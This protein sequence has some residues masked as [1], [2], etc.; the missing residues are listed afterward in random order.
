[1]EQ[2]HEGLRGMVGGVHREMKEALDAQRRD[3]ESVDAS[4]K[5][6]NSI[7]YVYSL[8]GN[9]RPSEARRPWHR[10]TSTAS[11]RTSCDRTRLR[12]KRHKGD[13]RR[14]G[15]VRDPKCSAYILKF[16]W[17]P[18]MMTRDLS[19]NSIHCP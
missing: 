13:A 6:L 15:S 4:L 3:I 2:V 1:M 10:Q 12:K 14:K 19:P 7:K 9:A 17:R 11:R 18:S 8:D 5:A 16:K